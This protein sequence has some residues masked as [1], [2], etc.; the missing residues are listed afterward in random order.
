MAIRHLCDASQY[1][2]Q[3]DHNL[4][5]QIELHRLQHV[6]FPIGDAG[7]T[8]YKIHSLCSSSINIVWCS[9]ILFINIFLKASIIGRKC[10]VNNIG[11]HFMIWLVDYLLSGMFNTLCSDSKC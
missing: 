11:Q 9:I 3:A 2:F 4:S 1:F 7:S 6:E 5:I 10:K 8:E